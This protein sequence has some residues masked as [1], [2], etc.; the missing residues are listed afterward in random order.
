MDMFSRTRMLLGSD[1]MERLAAARAAVFGI[2]GVGG[3]AFEAL[4][5][6]GIGE[7]DIFDNDEVCVSNLNRQLIATSNTIGMA[8]V[9]AARERALAI[10]PNITVNAHKCFFMPDNAD[11]YDFTKYSYIIDAVDTVTAKIELVMRAQAANVPIIS[12]MGTGNKLD[13]SMLEVTDIYKTS[14]C[15]LAKVMRHELKKRGV[16]HLT[17]VYSKEKPISPMNTENDGARRSVPGSTA[18]VPAAAG[19]IMAGEAVRYIAQSENI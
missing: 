12:C 7:I 14:M 19:L 15:P 13:A 2:G 16:K 17:V 4:V 5:R 18:F 1:G 3:Y 8:K 11:E 6:S 10:N 9:D